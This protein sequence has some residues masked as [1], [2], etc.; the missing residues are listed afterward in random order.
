MLTRSCSPELQ[1]D[2]EIEQTIKN[3]RAETRRK[4]MEREGQEERREEEPL[5]VLDNRT[6]MDYLAPANQTV[7]NA[8]SIPTIEA[9]NFEMRVPLIQMMQSIQFG[10]IPG[11]DPHMHIRKFL[12]LANTI[13]MNGVSTDTI[14]LMLFPFSVTDRVMN[15]FNNSLPE[16][17][18]TTWDQLQRQFLA[19]YFPPSLASKYLTEIACFSPPFPAMK[20]MLCR[21]FSPV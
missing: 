13:K 6:L 18:I 15:W 9:N 3:L 11:E 2:P 4:R 20:R 16:G 12:Q 21:R 19:H 1:F 17:S 7:R 10:G 5:T 14:R 8:I